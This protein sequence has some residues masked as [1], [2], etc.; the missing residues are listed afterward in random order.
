MKEVLEADPTL[1][2]VW[3]KGEISNFKHHSSGHMYFTLKDEKSRLK[4][5]MFRTRNA[6][7]RFRPEDGLT[8]IVGGSI[9]LY[10]VAGEYQLYV[11]ELYPAGRERS[12]S[13][14]SSS[15]RSSRKR[16]SSIPPASGPFPSCRAR[17]GWS[18]LRPAP[19]SAI[20]SA[21]CGDAFRT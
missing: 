15:S 20:S 14:S 13:L 12:T 4:C 3:V 19:P 17:S 7:L 10:E 8:V 2:A 16:G 1:G 5:V 9:G 6:A 18:P 21:C 11:N